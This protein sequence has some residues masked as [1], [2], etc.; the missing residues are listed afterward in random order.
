MD[1]GTGI[2]IS[3]AL[4]GGLGTAFKIFGSPGKTNTANLVTHPEC[5]A[6]SVGLEKLM[7]QG[8]SSISEDIKRLEKKMERADGLHTGEV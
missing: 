6:K 4:L 5:E 1:I 8:F 7:Q 3:T 2:I